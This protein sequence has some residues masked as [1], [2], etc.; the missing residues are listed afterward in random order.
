MCIASSPWAVILKIFVPVFYTSLV[1]CLNWV[2]IFLFVEQHGWAE[3]GSVNFIWM[4]WRFLNILFFEGGHL[5]KS[6]SVLKQ[7]ILTDKEVFRTVSKIRFKFL[8]HL[9]F[10]SQKLL[11]D[12]GLHVRYLMVSEI[13]KLKLVGIFYQF[14]ISLSSSFSLLSP[15]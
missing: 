1:K 13:F 3:N 8:H 4:T 10:F 15:T 6:M 2:L 7:E 11:K 14:I 12:E 9:F 5:Y